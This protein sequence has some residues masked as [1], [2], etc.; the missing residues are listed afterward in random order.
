MGE[1][2]SRRRI[3][4]MLMLL[5]KADRTTFEL[6]D[7]TGMDPENARNW[8]KVLEDEGLVARCGVRFK[9]GQRGTKPT[10]WRWVA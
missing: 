3:A 4:D 9:H 6:A 1:M 7:L 2:K 5:I 8:L 10:V